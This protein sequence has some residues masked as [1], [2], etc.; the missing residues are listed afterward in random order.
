M[1]FSLQMSDIGNSEGVKR[2]FI[3]RL[4][5]SSLECFAHA[6]VGPAKGE[7]C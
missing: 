2:A 6:K 5:S 7:K 1:D 3:L 4:F